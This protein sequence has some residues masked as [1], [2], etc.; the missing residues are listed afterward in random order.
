M[1]RRRLESTSVA[2]AAVLLAVGSCA[3]VLL[4]WRVAP[5]PSRT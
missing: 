1:N 5:S 4:A 3:G 2:V